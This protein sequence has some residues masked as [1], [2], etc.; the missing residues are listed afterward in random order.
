MSED[1]PAGEGTA[2]S[3]SPAPRR[4]R[5]RVRRAWRDYRSG[6]RRWSAV[7]V[8][9]L[10][11]AGALLSA[12]A[13]AA[14]GTS[15][16]AEQDVELRELI[17]ERN[18]QVQDLT[19]QYEALGTEVEE[20]AEGLTDDSGVTA[21]EERASEWLAAA[22]LTA[23]HGPGVQVSLD[24][25]PRVDGRLP[26]GATVDDVVVHQQDV[27]AVVNALWA[28][29]AEA[30]TIMGVRV[31]STSAVRCV[32]NTLLLHGQVYSPPFVIAAIGDRDAMMESLDDAPG[33]R[34]FRAAAADFGLGYST[35]EFEDRRM[36]AYDGPLNLIDAE[37]PR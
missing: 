18:A 30:M 28:G 22:G 14:G 7:T 2:P 4:A 17:P 8:L 29:G 9:V 33:V 13:S 10:F 21:E 15:L 27:Q 1:T 32:G 5:D 23:V 34:A 24:D 19:E 36:P 12:T 26:H 20:L 25:A 3:D 37:V 6:E 35:E 16:R 11:A 31:V